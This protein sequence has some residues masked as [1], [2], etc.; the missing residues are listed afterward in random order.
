MSIILLWRHLSSNRKPLD[1]LRVASNLQK[2]FAPLFRAPLPQ[3][4]QQTPGVGM[5]VLELPV[6]RWRPPFFQED[7]ET[8][9]LAVDYPINGRTVLAAKGVSVNEDNF[10]PALGRKL[11]EEPR[12]LLK[13]LAPPFSLIWSSKETGET[14]IQNDGLGQSQLF[15]YQDE[16]IWALSNK[17]SAFKALGLSLEPDPEQWA[18][19]ATLDWFPL[20][21]SGY[22]RIRYLEPATQLRLSA[23]GICRAKHDVL[24]DWVHPQ[25]LSEKDCLELA[26]SSMLELIKGCLPLWD[27]PSVGLSG[28]WDSRAVVSSLRA[29]GADFRAR[30]RGLP[31]RHD[32]VIAS[33]VARIAG[34]KLSVQHSGGLPAV[35]SDDCRRCISRALLW[36]AGHM[37]SHRHKTFLASQG[38]LQERSVS[39]TGQHGEIGRRERAFF[40]EYRRISP[41]ELTETQYEECA[42]REIMGFVPA[43]TKPSLRENVREIIRKTFHHADKYNLTGLA[44]L[45]FFSLYGFTRRKGSNVHAWQTRLLIAPFLN[46]GYIRAVFGYINRTDTNAFH[47]YLIAANSPDW[48]DVAFFEDLEERK[49]AAKGD[50]VLEGM[51]PTAEM[52]A[53]WKQPTGRDNYNRLQYWQDVG[54]PFIDEAL[55]QGGFWTEVFD[56]DLARDQWLRAA[57]EIAILYM[58][59]G[60]TAGA[61]ASS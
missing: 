38:F 13:D 46:P 59:P 29:A 36:Q 61:S 18:V 15:E 51:E 41:G 43:C 14:F 11:Q 3:R 54:K 24:S 48:V 8:W 28:G 39:I 57:D 49:L 30:V 34:F 47:R 45:D 33:E 56:P 7:Q 44:R 22:K 17:I 58:L 27:K 23:H 37:T 1:P 50:G 55:A 25:G 12:P 5:V 26:R 42:L 20:D 21:M 10:L 2:V 31:G 4:I 16:H 53:S 32:V 9:A 40:G 60:V 35:D 52:S 19:W 6:P